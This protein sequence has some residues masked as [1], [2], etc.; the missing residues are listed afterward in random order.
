VTLLHSLTFYCILLHCIQNFTDPA[1]IAMPPLH[2]AVE[3]SRE[4][5]VVWLIQEDPMRL[6]EPDY[7]RRVPAHRTACPRIAEMIMGY[8]PSSASIR[9]CYGRIPLH[10][11]PSPEMV[12]AWIGGGRCDPLTADT[13]GF[14]S[15]HLAAQR[16]YAD[17][18]AALVRLSPASVHAPDSRGRLPV[19]DAAQYGYE[20]T[21]RV[22][23]EA[24]PD[25]DLRSVVE[26]A[27]MHGHMDLVTYLDG[28]DPTA[29]ARG[30]PLHMAASTGAS[31]VVNFLLTKLSPGTMDTKGC[32]PLHYAALSG[33]PDCVRLLMDAGASCLAQ[34]TLGRLPL[35]YA[36]FSGSVD[37]VDLLLAIG[38]IET[39]LMCDSDGNVPLHFAAE[40][41]STHMV[42]HMFDTCPDAALLKNA[43]DEQALDIAVRG[44]RDDVIEALLAKY[45]HM[46]LSHLCHTPEASAV[47]PVKATFTTCTACVTVCA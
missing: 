45:E 8:A 4:A 23:V 13:Y 40:G 12:D 31:D 17:V 44:G 20:D 37:C 14:T 26:L 32:L 41:S 30:S 43:A 47:T 11:A 33:H 24:D 46:D 28:I 7:F 5:E 10:Y 39:A 36:A 3:M 9:D 22:L 35:H 34:D 19:H 1:A 18:A 2:D 25:M 38:G 15:L 27:A 42:T 29:C 21:L 6:W 16:G